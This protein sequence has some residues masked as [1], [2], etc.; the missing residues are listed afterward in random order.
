MRQNSRSF[1]NFTFVALLLACLTGCQQMS[2]VLPDKTLGV[3]S[4]LPG[5]Q[6]GLDEETQRSVNVKTAMAQSFERQGNVDLAIARYLEVLEKDPENANANHRLAVLHDKKGDS[7]TALKFY[8]TALDKDPENAQVLCDLGY[9]HH[10]NRRGK[11]AEDCL[12]KAIALEPNHHRAHNNLGLVL[13][14]TGRED[15]ALT[16]FLRAGLSEPEARSNLAFAMLMQKRQVDASH[17]YRIALQANPNLKS[18]RDGLAAI[19]SLNRELASIMP[20]RGSHPA[21]RLSYHG[22]SPAQPVMR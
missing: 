4:W 19:D 21:N 3:A 22:P 9:S 8:Q 5:G 14:H 11:E 16:E 17:Q 2:N 1:L 18:A 6:K 20:P 13:A 12:R 15:E 10:L 7:E